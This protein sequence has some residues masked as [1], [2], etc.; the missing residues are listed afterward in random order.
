MNKEEE[1]RKLLN[2]L[3]KESDEDIEQRKIAKLSEEEKVLHAFSK[4]LTTLA[5][6]LNVPGHQKTQDHRVKRLL[7]AISKE[8]F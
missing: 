3:N 6:D 8:D 7:D 5:R 4:K 2:E 1:N